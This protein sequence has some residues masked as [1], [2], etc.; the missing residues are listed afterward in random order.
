MSRVSLIVTSVERWASH[1]SG[2]TDRACPASRRSITIKA[3]ALLAG[4]REPHEPKSAKGQ[5]TRSPMF[6]YIAQ[7]V[8]L[9]A[10]CIA[11][12][13]WLTAPTAGLEGDVYFA[14]F[15]LPP[16]IEQQLLALAP[17]TSPADS[18]PLFFKPSLRSRILPDTSGT[19]DQVLANIATMTNDKAPIIRHKEDFSYKGYWRVTVRGTPGPRPRRR[20][21]SHF[22]VLR[23]PESSGAGRGTTQ[24]KLLPVETARVFSLGNI[25]LGD[26]GRHGP[27]LDEGRGD[28]RSG[29]PDHLNP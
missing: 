29:A 6:K 19:V 21:P 2:L 15:Q 25:Q 3:P 5:E 13:T 24:S 10:T 18:R 11:V 14:D 9:L 4:A 12:Y 8:G 1:G 27:R 23:G 20:W 22:P 17:L 7:G 16:S 28:G 26:D